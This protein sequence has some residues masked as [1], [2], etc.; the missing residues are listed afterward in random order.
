MATL[1]KRKISVTIDEDLIQELEAADQSLSAQVNAA[2]RA[3]IEQRARHRLLAELLDELDDEL[4][5]VDEA[6]I[7]KYVRMLE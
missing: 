7:D 6:L 2:V 1:T 5:P 3:Q 4:G